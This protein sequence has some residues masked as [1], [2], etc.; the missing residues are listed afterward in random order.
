[1]AT[2]DV[3]QKSRIYHTLSELNTAFAA[4]V[5]HCDTLQQTGLFK[6][7]AAKLFSSFTQELQAEINQE[8]LEDL[9]QLELDDW[10]RHGKAR[11]KWEKYLRDPDDVFIHAEERRKELAKQRKKY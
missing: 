9:H 3:T 8:F 6:S 2:I 4:I 1:M 11:Q 5:G 10:G 7:K